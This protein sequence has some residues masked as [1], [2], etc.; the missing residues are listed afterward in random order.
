M[1]CRLQSSSQLSHK[2]NRSPRV[3]CQYKAR[4]SWKQIARRIEC[5]MRLIHQR[6]TQLSNHSSNKPDRLLWFLMSGQQHQPPRPLWRCMWWEQRVWLIAW[7]SS[8]CA[9]I[10]A[11]Q[12]VQIGTSQWIYH[13]IVIQIPNLH[14]WYNIWSLNLHVREAGDPS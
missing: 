4:G 6:T 12:S 13:S 8:S 7:I 1:Y 5:S 14:R 11:N 10:S 9:A 2:Y 3:S